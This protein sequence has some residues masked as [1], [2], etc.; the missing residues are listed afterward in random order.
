[1]DFALSDERQLIVATVRRF[2][3]RE[4][5]DICAEA[6]RA[7]N[8]PEQLLAVAGEVGFLVDAVPADAGG[9]LDEQYSHTT[10]ALRAMELGRGCAGISALLESN[11]EPALAVAE[12]GTERAREALFSS[13]SE[14]GLATTVRDV[15]R[16]VSIAAAGDGLTL[17]GVL[18]PAPA[19]GAAKYVLLCAR[20]DA[21][22]DGR[23]DGG[24][25][26]LCLVPTTLGRVTPFTPSGWRA[27]GWGT[28]TLDAAR[29]PEALVL[30]SGDHRAVDTVLSW[31]R[32]CLAARAVGVARAAMAH[33]E[34]YGEE[35]VQFGQP[36]G[37]FESIVAMRDRTRPWSPRPAC[38]CCRRPGSW[39]AITP[40]PSTR[41]AAPA[42]WPRTWFPER[43]S[44]RCRSMVAT[45]S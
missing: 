33:A 41:S 5:V 22:T 7:G 25:P 23:D 28:L 44:T 6:D 30:A 12:W 38:W 14:G 40:M 10:R 32:L 9:L 8:V 29:L 11:V 34:R 21:G 4:V 19:L 35:R 1:M 42:T 26:V 17:S 27:A 45:D 18:G 39:T 24:S 15:N 3:D 37:T 20:I 16:T 36:I 31:Y 13:L 2:V 43:P